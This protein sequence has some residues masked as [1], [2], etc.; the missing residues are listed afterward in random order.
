MAHITEI[1][2][3]IEGGLQSDVQKIISYSKLLSENLAA[4]GDIKSSKRIMDKLNG[5][6]SNQYFTQKF[7]K[8]SIPIDHESKL[9]LADELIVEKDSVDIF[10][11]DQINSEI[12]NFIKYINSSD[13]LIKEG[14]GISPTMLIYGP[15]GCGKTQLA[16]YIASQLNMPLVLSRS[17]TL[18]SSYLGNT[19]KNIRR[20]FEHISSKPCILF[21]D[22]FDALAKVRD[23]HNE[24][25]E[26]KRVVVSL[27]QNIDAL[28]P[29]TILLAATNHDHL[30][31]PAIWRRFNFKINLTLP[32]I[33]VRK[34]LIVKYCNNSITDKFANLLSIASEELS[35]SEI[36]NVIENSLRKKIINNDK[37][38]DYES[39]IYN[40]INLTKNKDITDNKESVI[41]Y[42]RQLDNKAFTYEIISDIFKYST[43]KIS[44]I[45][46]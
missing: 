12:S 23:D 19:A 28:D 11:S 14:V 13:D 31:D 42:L 1:L 4:S 44:N 36:R 3:I 17:D 20:L 40:F 6:N 24:L 5:K 38:I 29:N 15:P 45:L 2:K 27:L 10:L 30:L 32:S 39:T 41:K 9:E 18:I 46:K 37:E 22:E 34:Q 33:D 21:L 26:L 25:G 35:G 16:Y 43:G 7:I 8:D